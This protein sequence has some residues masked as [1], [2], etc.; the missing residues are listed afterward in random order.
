M[1][2]VLILLIAILFPTIVCAK[3]ITKEDL[4]EAANYYNNI[5]D[6]EERKYIEKDGSCTNYQ[7]IEVTDDKVIVTDSENSTTN[8]DVYEFTYVINDNGTVVFTHT[9]EI[10]KGMTKEEYDDV[11]S[12]SIT[13]LYPSLLVAKANG[14]RMSD[15]GTYISAILLG[16][17]FDALN[18][19]AL[20]GFKYIIVADGVTVSNPDDY[21]FVIPENEFGDYVIRIAEK[22]YENPLSL[23]DD[24]TE[25]GEIN[26][27]VLA[28]T[29]TKIDDENATVTT[30][31]TVDSN[32]DYTKVAGIADRADDDTPGDDGHGSVDPTTQEPDPEPA[33]A[34]AP[35]KKEDNP[36]TGAAVN[37]LIIGLMLIVAIALYR[38]YGRRLI[39]KI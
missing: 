2:K 14:A 23:K 16:R 13:V 11:G 25:D 15:Y 19:N 18:E 39:Q 27:F 8:P 3:T 9:E 24:K 30:S 37:A 31:V 29:F 6:S 21:D 12:N 17:V 38:I 36:K 33:P 26:S 22:Q 28:I 10:K 35:Q 4:E 5:C 1:K 20:N 32:A 34:P 7:N